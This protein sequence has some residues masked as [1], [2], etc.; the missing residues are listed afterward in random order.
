[1]NGSVVVVESCGAQSRNLSPLRL[2]T[3]YLGFL[4]TK[5]S[6]IQLARRG[7]IGYSIVEAERSRGRGKSHLKVISANLTVA[8]RRGFADLHDGLGAVHH[9]LRYARY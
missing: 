8:E 7:W 6:I 1:M 2:W 3:I 5:A 4:Y 9:T